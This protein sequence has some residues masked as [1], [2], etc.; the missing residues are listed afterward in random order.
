MT[1]EALH[2]NWADSAFRVAVGRLLRLPE[3][4]MLK[5]NAIDVERG[6]NLQDIESWMLDDSILAAW[7]A[8]RVHASSSK[9]VEGFCDELFNLI[10]N[11]EVLRVFLSEDAEL[12]IRR[13]LAEGADP[14]VFEDYRAQWSMLPALIEASVSVDARV[15]EDS[16]GLSFF[17]VVLVRLEFDEPVA[18]GASTVVFQAPELELRQ[19]LND[20]SRGLDVADQVRIQ[21]RERHE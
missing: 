20:A 8:L 11:D 16:N 6:T 21:L 15:R 12:L 1:I 17:P 13:L 9:S 4:Q 19:L 10:R 14:N 2:T 3:D 5:L 7:A 18:G